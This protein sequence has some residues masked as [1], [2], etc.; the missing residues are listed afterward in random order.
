MY[1]K[2]N[3]A[4]FSTHFKAFQLS[5]RFTFN[6]FLHTTGQWA[7][8]SSQ[9]EIVFAVVHHVAVGLSVGMQD[10]SQCFPSCSSKWYSVS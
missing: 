4:L 5:P 2:A 1:Y 8:I 9:K 7:Q 3:I 6:T 10:I